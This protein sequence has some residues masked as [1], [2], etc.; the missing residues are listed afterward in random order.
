LEAYSPFSTQ[1]EAAFS[2]DSNPWA[3]GLS[4]QDPEENF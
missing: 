4:K 2:G 3:K 1:G